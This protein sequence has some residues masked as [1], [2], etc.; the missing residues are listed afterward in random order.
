[1]MYE[2]EIRA[3]LLQEWDPFCIG[4]NPNLADEYDPFISQI[5]FRLQAHHTVEEIAHYLVELEKELEA[6]TSDAKRLTT[7]TAL[8]TLAIPS[9]T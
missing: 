2:E 5:L 9:K 7:A 8:K 4:S 1:M 3:I 6:P